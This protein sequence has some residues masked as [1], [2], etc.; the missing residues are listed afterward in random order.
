[1]STKPPN[2]LW[3]AALMLPGIVGGTAGCSRAGPLSPDQKVATRQMTELV[4]RGTT[5]ARARRALRDRGFALSRLSSDHATNHLII[6]TYTKGDL[7]WQVG[8]IIVDAKVA[9]TSVTVTDY[10]VVDK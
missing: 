10:S 8:L 1:M 7:A 2:A 4:P 6:A 5:E 3:L 9:A